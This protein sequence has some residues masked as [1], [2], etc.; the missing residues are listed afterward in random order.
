MDS[1]LPPEI[2]ASLICLEIKEQGTEGSKGERS[3][4]LNTAASRRDLTDKTLGFS[5]VQAKALGRSPESHL[6][7]SLCKPPPSRINEY[8]VWI[9]EHEKLSNEL[10]HLATLRKSS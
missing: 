7:P 10:G 4:G 5:S 3:K 8:S 1:L 6:L 9:K 2:Q